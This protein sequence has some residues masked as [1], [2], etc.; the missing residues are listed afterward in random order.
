MVAWE[1][2]GGWCE[3]RVHDWVGHRVVPGPLS[4]VPCVWR[5]W[6]VPVTCARR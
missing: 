4:P 2:S 6:L 1:L 3:V 5:L